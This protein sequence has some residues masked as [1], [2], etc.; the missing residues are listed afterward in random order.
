MIEKIPFRTGDIGLVHVKY[1]WYDYHTWLAPFIRLF[2]RVYYNHVFLIVEDNGIFYRFEAT[3]HGIEK[4]LFIEKTTRDDNKISI[5]RP[6]FDI[7]DKQFDQ[8]RSLSEKL[9]GTPYDWKGTLFDQLIYQETGKWIGSTNENVEN[10]RFYCSEFVMFVYHIVFG[11]PEF[12]QFYESDPR[13]IMNLTRFIKIFTG[14]LEI[15][16][17]LS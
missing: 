14:K 12:K 10:K 9:K 5:I 4:N 11:F 16:K 7:T 13:Y 2:D 17:Y 1:K 6:T 3:E 15:S 8:I